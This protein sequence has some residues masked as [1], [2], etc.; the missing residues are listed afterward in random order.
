MIHLEAVKLWVI[1]LR[2]AKGVETGNICATKC[3]VEDRR[4]NLKQNH[5]DDRIHGVNL[6]GAITWRK[7]WQS[8]SLAAS[9]FPVQ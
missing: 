6:P 1:K 9:H 4:R 2:D 3:P 8:E 5:C 7:G